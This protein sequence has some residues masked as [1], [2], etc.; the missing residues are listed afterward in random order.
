MRMAAFDS[1]N[2]VKAILRHK[3]GIIKI[4]IRVGVIIFIA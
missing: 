4:L 3:E 1:S 2:D